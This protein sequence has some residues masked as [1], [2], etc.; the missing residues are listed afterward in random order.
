M[1]ANERI[2]VKSNL[3]ITA[4]ERG[5]ICARREGHNIW[6][7]TGREWLAQLIAYSNYPTCSTTY[8][9]HRAKYMG[10]G[11]GGTRQLLVAEAEAA[12]LDVYDEPAAT[13]V[14]TDTEPTITTLERPVRISGIDD[15]SPYADGTNEWLATIGDVSFPTAT[16]TLFTRLFEQ[17]DVSYDPFTMV[18]LSEIMLFTA[19]ANPSLFDNTGIAY[20]TFDTIP[21]TGAIDFEVAWTIR[22]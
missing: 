15:S 3:I 14:Q 20:D 1:R 7:N 8:E 16:Q 12:P 9:D 13:Y 22:F 11:M 17:T 18:P 21:K 6:L 5:K 2:E 10:V 4:R 19:A